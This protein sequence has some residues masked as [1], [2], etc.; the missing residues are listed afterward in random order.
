MSRGEVD[1]RVAVR[2]QRSIDVT[3]FVVVSVIGL[4]IANSVGLGLGFVAQRL[5]DSV[6]TPFYE[7]VANRGTSW[8]TDVLSV[9]TKM[10]NVPQTKVLTVVL[11]VVLAGYFAVRGSRWWMPLLALPGAWIVTR[12]GQRVLAKIIDRDAGLPSITGTPIGDFPS[13]GCARIIV[14]L[15]TAVLLLVHYLRLSRRT[16]RVLIGVVVLAGLVEAYCRASLNQH[17]LTDVISGVLYGAMMMAV[18]VAALR[19]LDPDPPHLRAHPG[20]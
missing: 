10:G 15:G 11:A 1:D 4:A 19:A 13:G 7:S 8:W 18:I 6:D 9:V 14:V 20:E 5:Q 16:S 2:P 12:L 3:R 17:W